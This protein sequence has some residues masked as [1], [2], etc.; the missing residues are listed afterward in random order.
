MLGCEVQE[1]LLCGCLLKEETQYMMERKQVTLLPSFSRGP[2]FVFMSP[3]KSMI[4]IS[5]FCHCNAMRE[6]PNVVGKKNVP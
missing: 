6:S 4:P 2:A 3:D 1:Y 5:D